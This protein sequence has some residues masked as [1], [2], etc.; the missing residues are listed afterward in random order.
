MAAA[1]TADEL[2]LVVNPTSVESHLYLVGPAGVG[3]TSIIKRVLFDLGPDDECDQA[4]SEILGH[5]LTTEGAH[6]HTEKYNIRFYERSSAKALPPPNSHERM[7]V[8]YVLYDDEHGSANDVLAG[9][10]EI[11]RELRRAYNV[12]LVMAR[13]DMWLETVL[14]S[15]YTGARRTFELPLEDPPKPG[16][17]PVDPKVRY[18][19]RRYGP[20]NTQILSASSEHGIES[21]LKW[22]TEKYWNLP[23]RKTKHGA[24]ELLL[25]DLIG[26]LKNIRRDH[27]N[28]VVAVSGRAG[29]PACTVLGVTYNPGHRSVNGTGAYTSQAHS[30]PLLVLNGS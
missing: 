14:K 8:A 13:C 12:C 20:A 16:A 18:V 11:A 7:F 2:L 6:F 26:Q 9:Q 19:N 4:Q 3:K 5:A 27:G 22:V 10:V 17:K 28:V 24:S 15:N 25:D 23:S 29:A 21:L 1:L 30:H